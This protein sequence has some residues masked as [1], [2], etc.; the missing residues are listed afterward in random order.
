[1]ENK[2]IFKI[3]RTFK[4]MR[5]TSTNDNDLTQII[6]QHCCDYVNEFEDLNQA[7]EWRKENQNFENEYT[8]IPCY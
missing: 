8:I 7:I 1:M 4:T 5:L 2:V 3:F 6:T